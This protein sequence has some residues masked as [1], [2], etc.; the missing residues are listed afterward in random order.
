LSDD[1][2]LDTHVLVWW[3]TGSDELNTSMVAR[4]DRADR[5]LVSA[6][7]LWEIVLKEST[8]H[9]MVGTDDAHGWFADAMELSG[10]ERLDITVRDLG[11]V[12]HLPIV[13]RDPFDRL[14]IAQARRRGARIVTKD[15]TIPRYEVA[16]LVVP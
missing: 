9:P 10:F 5:V 12:Q 16:T 4:I 15:A 14:L 2:L 8:R 11:D 7:S 1:L 3:A 6:V 13:H